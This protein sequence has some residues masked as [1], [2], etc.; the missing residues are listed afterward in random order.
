MATGVRSLVRQRH[1]EW[2]L[3]VEA[4]YGLRGQLNLLAFACSLHTT[5]KSTAGGCSDSG[6]LTT[7]GNASD[8]GA[9][10]R[11]RPYFFGGIRGTVAALAPVWVSLERRTC[12]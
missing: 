5:A 8:D 10:Q 11:A 9:N 3:Q 2:R 4:Q 1:H 6:A 12:R 7:S